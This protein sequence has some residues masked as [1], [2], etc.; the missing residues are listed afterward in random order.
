M[1]QNIRGYF[2][3]HFFSLIPP[4]HARPVGLFGLLRSATEPVIGT[5]DSFHQNVALA[6]VPTLIPGGVPLEPPCRRGFPQL[7][8]ISR[9][10]SLIP[11]SYL[12]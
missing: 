10:A 6:Y 4:D 1:P 9:L 5:L 2:N 12:V 8:L 11:R 3:C 7:G